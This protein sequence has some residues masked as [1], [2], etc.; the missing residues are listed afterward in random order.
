MDISVSNLYCGEMALV[1]SSGNSRYRRVLHSLAVW[2][3][4]L[5]PRVTF[6]TLFLL[7]ALLTGYDD[8]THNQDLSITRLI[9][10]ADQANV[11]LVARNIVEGRGAVVD[12]IWL[13]TNGG[14][15]GNNIPVPEPYWSIY[16]AAVIAIFFSM[17]GSTLTAMLLPAVLTKT[18]IAAVAAQLTLRISKHYLPAFA[19]AVFLLCDTQMETAV[20]GLSDIYLTLFMLLACW[21]FSH[22][23]SSDSA[24]GFLVTGLLIGVAIG[25]KPSGLLLL[26]LLLGYLLFLGSL[27]KT[28]QRL[29]ITLIGIMIGL[30]PLAV[31]NYQG[32][33]SVISPAHALVSDAD[34]I[35]FVT[36]NHSKAFYDPE[37]YVFSQEELRLI[38]GPHNEISRAKDFF[39]ALIEGKIFPLWLLPF[40]AIAVGWSLLNVRSFFIYRHVEQKQLAGYVFVQM[41]IAAIVLGFATH[42]EPRYWLFALPILAI[43]SIVIID[44][45]SS[46]ATIA[47]IVFLLFSATSPNTSLRSAPLP[48]WYDI[49]ATVLPED[50]IVL[51]GTPWQFA[52]HTRRSAVALP[53]TENPEVL[54]ALAE[55]YHAEYIAIL[56][57]GLRNQFYRPIIENNLPPYLEPFHISEDLVIVK[58]K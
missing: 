28:V 5:P 29:S 31:H 56:G 19:V 1:N 39:A 21:A 54:L 33:D 36:G 10:H 58:F 44:R 7:L 30:A 40:A 16:V 57:G 23:V 22:A 18:A 41:M 53:D 51:T 11:A 35:R 26:G 43:A 2:Q 9:G 46:K 13:H 55:R 34:K 48:Q 4:K 3:E 25:I 49:A 15:E 14:L 38:E 20:S 24:P 17:L 42:M 47:L 6:W 50:A 37:P 27:L 45:I 52:F 12:A 8:V 32:F